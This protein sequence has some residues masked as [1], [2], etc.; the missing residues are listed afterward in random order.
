MTNLRGEKE[1][2][3]EQKNF[4][5]LLVSKIQITGG[6]VFDVKVFVVKDGKLRTVKFLNEGN[7]GDAR[8][9]GFEPITYLG[10]GKI[11]VPWWTNAPGSEGRYR[12]I[13]NLDVENLILVPSYTKKT[14]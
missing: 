6:V 2:E 3:D 1:H 5:D 10:D 11:S 4:P 7:L 8:D 12:T 13:Y 9:T 14:S